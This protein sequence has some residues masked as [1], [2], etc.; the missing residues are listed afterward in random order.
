MDEIDQALA[1]TIDEL[2]ALDTD[3]A[4]LMARGL[5]ILTGR[6][7]AE[8]RERTALSI[9]VG[10][11][12]ERLPARRA[13]GR[14]ATVLRVPVV[15]APDVTDQQVRAAVDDLPRGLSADDAI[16]ALEGKGLLIRERGR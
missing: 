15:L 9:A 10:G 8:R 4:R 3:E 11:L 5:R 7:D 12:A 13:V 2:E 16:A 14:K 1:E 6:V